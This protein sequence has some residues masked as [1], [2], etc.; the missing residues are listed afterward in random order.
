MSQ[1]EKKKLRTSWQKRNLL[2]GLLQAVSSDLDLTLMVKAFKGLEPK[3]HGFIEDDIIDVEF[4]LFAMRCARISTALRGAKIGQRKELFREIGMS[5]TLGCWHQWSWEQ[6]FEPR[7]EAQGRNCRFYLKDRNWFTSAVKLWREYDIPAL[8]IYEDMEESKRN[9]R[10]LTCK[11]YCK[12]FRDTYERPE[13]TKR[14]K[15]PTLAD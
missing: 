6:I 8:S 5:N 7:I 15:K 11:E 14:Q 2:R 1:S 3:D 9:K 10:N 4:R 13:H 12:N